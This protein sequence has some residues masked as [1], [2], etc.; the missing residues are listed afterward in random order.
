[1]SEILIVR[2]F[3]GEQIL[4]DVDLNHSATHIKVK[5]PTI[6]QAGPN[7]RTG[8][9]DVHMAPLLTLAEEKEVEIARASLMF[10]YTP[11]VD[12]KN[13]FNQLFGSGIVLADP[14]ALLKP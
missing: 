10:H 6:I 8:Q 7:P 9:V 14:S 13:K 3:T 1:M 2:L 5:H 11:V 12:I 4:G